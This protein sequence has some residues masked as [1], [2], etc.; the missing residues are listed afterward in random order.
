M[1]KITFLG[2]IFSLFTT[3]AFAQDTCFI[4]ESNTPG[5]FTYEITQDGSGNYFLT[6]NFAV[7]NGTP[8]FQL[9]YGVGAGPFGA[10]S[11]QDGVPFP[12]NTFSNGDIVNIQYNYS[13][14]SQGGNNAL[15]NHSFEYGSCPVLSNES[16][17]ANNI[18][19]NLTVAN[20]PTH[21]KNVELGGFNQEVSI[22]LY[23]FTSQLVSINTTNEGS[24]S[25]ETTSLAEGLYFVVIETTD[26]KQ[27]KTI[28]V[29]VNN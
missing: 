23:D 5:E 26:G 22:S 17:I 10:N 15:S 2:L 1:R 28:K 25:I 19:N 24:H 27:T 16:H 13:S 3:N 18:E 20:N 4:G 21:G 14:A 7:G 11:P 8:T 29:T 6:T 12:L 9:F